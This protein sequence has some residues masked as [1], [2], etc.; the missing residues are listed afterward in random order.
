MAAK[1]SGPSNPWAASNN[2][3]AEMSRLNLDAKEAK[4]PAADSARAATLEAQ[5][6]KGANAASAG[7]AAA[8]SQAANG[9][10][11]V[12]YSV[13]ELQEM[14][15]KDLQEIARDAGIDTKGMSKDELIDALAD[16]GVALTA[17][18]Q[19]DEEEIVL[20]DDEEDLESEEI[21]GE[22][23]LEEALALLGEDSEDNSDF[24]DA[25]F[26]EVE[27]EVLE[28]DADFE[29]DDNNSNKS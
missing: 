18:N 14:S 24:S 26:E 5:D 11:I 19:E 9:D 17:E 23:S 27:T 29:L 21:D 3:W 25:E 28:G 1:N 10:E 16:S 22:M 12:E 8:V 7:A 20:G 4:A 6:S 13:D 2:P 15:L